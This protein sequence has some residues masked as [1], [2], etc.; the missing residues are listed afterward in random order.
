MKYQIKLDFRFDLNKIINLIDLSKI[1]KLD[2][3]FDLNIIIKLDF[4]FK[5]N[6]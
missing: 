3:R 2:F 6:Y 1:I 4:R 5:H